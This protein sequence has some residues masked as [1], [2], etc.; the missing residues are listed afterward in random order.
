MALASLEHKI[1][2]NFS[3][4]HRYMTKISQNSLLANTEVA[5]HNLK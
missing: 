4:K 3:N 5:T 1:Q 2:N